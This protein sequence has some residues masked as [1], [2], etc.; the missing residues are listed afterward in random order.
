MCM[1]K[2]KA[3]KKNLFVC[4][5]IATGFWTLNFFQPPQ[6]FL[7]DIIDFSPFYIMIINGV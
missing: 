3:E 4:Y 6:N 2:F 7:M 5:D 1:K